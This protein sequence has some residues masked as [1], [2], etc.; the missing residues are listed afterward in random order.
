MKSDYFDNDLASQLYLAKEE[1]G[2][3]MVEAAIGLPIF[4]LL[5]A[6]IIDFSMILRGELLV[7]QAISEAGRAL[8][9]VSSTENISARDMFFK[10]GQVFS[11]KTLAFG[12]QA[13]QLA[14]GADSED[15][16]FILIG[17]RFDFESEGR[18]YAA[19]MAYELQA[20]YSPS[21]FFCG[22]LK[23]QDF[24][25]NH[26]A[27]IIMETYSWDWNRSVLPE[28]VLGYFPGYGDF[29]TVRDVS[30]P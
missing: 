13:E 11:E 23:L 3:T 19:P 14:I 16:P 2:V 20:S 8:S 29:G 28:D 17:M 30:P 9:G 24:R 27:L 7:A 12:L 6:A 18:Q 1:S 26:S 4:L 21:C 15:Q 10:A 5:V 25:I 22:L